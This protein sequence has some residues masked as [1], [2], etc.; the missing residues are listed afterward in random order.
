[1]WWIIGW[2]IL[3]LFTICNYFIYKYSGVN[4][5]GWII[6]NIV[7]WIGGA[8]FIFFIGYLIHQK[9]KETAPEREAKKAAIEEENRI[10]VEEMATK[11]R[12]QQ[13]EAYARRRQLRIE[14]EK[15][16]RYSNWRKDVF[17]K[18]GRQCEMCGEING[19]EIHHRTSFDSILRLYKINTLAEAFECD[20]LWIINNGSVLCKKHHD[21]MQSSEYYNKVAI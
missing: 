3:I 17:E 6:S 7:S 20:A 21:E 9:F 18:N 5:G 1:M 16:P 4:I 14:I 19:L 11:V 8:F 2:S 12:R 15:M 10:R 13:E